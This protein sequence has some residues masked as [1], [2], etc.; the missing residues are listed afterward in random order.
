MTRGFAVEIKAGGDPR[1]LPDYQTLCTEMARLAHPACPAVNWRAIEH[2]CHALFASNGADLQT[3]AAYALARSHLAGLDGMFEG[4]V[5]LDTLLHA[6]AK[7]WP[8]GLSAQTA[9]VG[10]L[11]GQWQAVLRGLEINLCDLAGL[12][13]L[14][15]QLEHLRQMPVAQRLE[16]IIALERLHQ[17]IG[18][19]AS[20]IERD[21]QAAEVVGQQA[22]PDP[23][24]PV[25]IHSLVHCTTQS[26]PPGMQPK[27]AHNIPR[28]K[29]RRASWIGWLVAALFILIIVLA[30]AC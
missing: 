3:A 21:A 11:F 19:L 18:Q 12:R 15:S 13:L 27:A 4:V 5:V 24:L 30:A 10:Q 17:Q 26:N 29:R 25:S 23:T 20:R 1:A 28:I 2:C 7:P 8:R 16:F 9:I 14:G 22:M 6:D